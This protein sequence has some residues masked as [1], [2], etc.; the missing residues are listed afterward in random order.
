M[1]VNY[2]VDLVK[3]GKR[4]TIEINP[5][6][7][8]IDGKTQENSVLEVCDFSPGQRAKVINITQTQ[9]DLWK[10][11]LDMSEFFAL[12]CELDENNHYGPD[13][14]KLYKWHE[15]SSYPKDHRDYIHVSENII[16]F[17]LI[18][19]K[20]NRLFNEWNTDKSSNLSYVEWLENRIM[21]DD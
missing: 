5:W 16:E 18:K 1:N 9:K 4:P 8:T 12:N 10:V 14:N 17:H 3:A 7:V 19:E 20:S 2:L 15:L 21:G 11:Y 6:E 13:T